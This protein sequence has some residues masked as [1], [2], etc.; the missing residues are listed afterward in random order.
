MPYTV[1]ASRFATL[2]R[3]LEASTD[4]KAIALAPRF[5]H[6]SIRHQSTPTE[7]S[8]AYLKD[9]GE[10]AKYEQT[11]NSLLITTVLQPHHPLPC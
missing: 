10:R 9:A 2:A 1:V 6:G 11:G 4:P 7:K 8:R 3:T 5:G